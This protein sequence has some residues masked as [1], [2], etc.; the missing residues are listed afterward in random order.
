MSTTGSKQLLGAH[1]SIAGGVFNAIKHGQRVGCD[2]IQMFNK[3]NNQWRAKQLLPKEIDTFF[4]AIDETGVTAC[5]SH[6]SYLIN[7]ASPNPE[8]SE[9]SRLALKEEMERCAVLKIPN[10]V[11]HPGAHVGS[12]EEAGLEQIAK[13][14]NLLF[15]EL[16]E[17]DVHLLL[18]TTAGQ[19]STLGYRFE[20]LAQ[21][22]AAVSPNDR[23]GVCLDTCHVFAA[24]YPL[25]DPAE[26]QQ[27][28]QR[29]DSTIGLNR[30]RIIHCNDSKKGIGS[31][32]DRHEQIGDGMIGLEGFRNLMN[33]PR[34]AAIPKIL[35]TPKDEETLAED[36]ENLRRL[37]S[38]IA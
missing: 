4:K 30:L 20:H 6:T 35:E 36:V 14:L 24:G 23:L 15:A 29:F 37:R 3:A 8:L 28:M 33:D 27:T 18:E 10:L 38:L 21:L 1:E 17:T 34:L 9:K 16:G 13:N 31:K 12:G 26:Y 19:G 11:M 2:T 32:V 25:A 22:I 7:I 5:T